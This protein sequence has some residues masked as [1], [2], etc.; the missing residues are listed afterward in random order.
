MSG[1]G[2]LTTG[3]IRLLDYLAAERGLEWSRRWAVADSC[4]MGDRSAFR[5]VQGL[6][7][8]GLV[9]VEHRGRVVWIRAT[10]LGI[11][12]MAARYRTEA[13]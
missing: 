4:N 9:E 1:L 11:D 7:I 5:A 13:A 12:L 10:P 3:A 6:R 8:W 2:S